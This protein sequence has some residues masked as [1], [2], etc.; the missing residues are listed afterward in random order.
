MLDLEVVKLLSDKDSY[1]K[2]QKLINRSALGE[3]AAT[4]IKALGMWHSSMTTFSWSKFAAWFGLVL[5]SKMDAGKMAVYKELFKQLE[6]DP[7]FDASESPLLVASLIKRDYATKAAEVALAIADGGKDDLNI[8]D[9]ITADYRRAA[10]KLDGVEG[11]IVSTDLASVIGKLKEPG[12]NWRLECLNES[13]GQLRKGDLI[14]VSTRP[15]TGKT[16]FCASEST[17][18][19]PQLK[20]DEI[21]L[22]INNEEEGGKVFGRV[23]QSAL[24]IERDELEADPSRAAANYTKLLGRADKILIFDKADAS[25]RDVELLLERHKVGLIIF[26]QLWK[27]HGFREEAGNEVTR[28]T[29]LFNWGR[30]ISKKHAP[31][32]AVHQADGSAEGVRWISMA[33]LYGSKTGIQGEADAIITIGR[34]PA[35]GDTRYLYVPKNKL[36][37]SKKSMRNGKYEIQILPHIG[38]FKEF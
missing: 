6:A 11:H 27:L 35:T 37:G 13:V 7:A 29:M 38:R 17:F 28:Q 34:D 3:E 8:L 12:L 5:H 31:V 20:D 14:V 19:A 32:I 1:N 36:G 24:A 4:I 30:E 26:D 10:G 9:S 22:W 18:M 33:Q 21:V 23:A 2:Y 15:D 16:T 25:V